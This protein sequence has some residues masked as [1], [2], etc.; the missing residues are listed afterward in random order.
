M[1]R[2]LFSALA[3]MASWPAVTTAQMV[4]DGAGAVTTEEVSSFVLADRDGDGV[5]VL[6]EFRVFVRHMASAGQPT[7][8]LIRTF[9]A[10]RRA[11]R[12]ADRDRNGEVTPG[13]LREADDAFR[14]DHG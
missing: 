8:R 9:G 5:L 13:E 4:V 10:Y 1:I 7:A 6:D 2:A 12:I 11:F 3:I 14:Q